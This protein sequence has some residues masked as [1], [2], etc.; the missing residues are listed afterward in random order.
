MHELQQ[1][2][3][4]QLFAAWRYRWLAIA[5]SWLVCAVGWTM[6][7]RIPNVYESSGR[8]YVDTDAILTPLLRGLTVDTGLSAQIELLQ[9]TLLSRPSLEKLISKTDLELQ[10]TSQADKE[11]LAQQLAGEIHISPQTRNLFTVSYRNQSPKL[12]YDVVQAMLTAFIES[13]AG[14]NRSDLANASRFLESQ[15]NLYERQLRE[16]E[17]RRAEFHAKY[18]DV[19]PQDGGLSRLEGANGAV[20]ALQGQLV[21]ATGARANLTKELAATPPMLV[22]EPEALG[23]AGGLT[24]IQ[25]AELQLQ[26]LRLRLTDKHPDVIAQREMIAALKSGSLGSLPAAPGAPAARA[27]SVPNPLYEQIKT[28][29]VDTDGQIAS[30]Q[31]QLQEQTEERDRLNAI[32]RGA[33]GLLAE[34]ININRDYE[35]LR[36]NYDE[37]LSRRESMR[38]SSAAEASADN[39]KIQLID[40]PIVPR[41]PIAPKRT[42]LLTG[43]LFGGLAA[44]LGLALALVQFDQSFHSTDDLRGL[45]YPV[46]GGVSM[47]AVATPFIRQAL[48]IGSFACAAAVPCVVYGGLVLTVLRQGTGA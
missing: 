21:D 42:V 4:K 15:I 2:V 36:R 33:P 45:G 24:R 9:R 38:I 16:A 20:K 8:M 6:V 25:Q 18:L 19:L 22:V 11:A 5:F 48:T 34:A 44:G 14:T 46:V 32:A 27:R 37:L 29:M 43:V 30:L 28:R 47:L 1:L 41:T 10:T 12:A 35:V 31:R 40:P 26:E 13:K 3:R 23:G 39:V 17:R 7:M